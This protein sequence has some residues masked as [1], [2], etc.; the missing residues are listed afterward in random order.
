MG[1]VFYRAFGEKKMTQYF[2]RIRFMR[3]SSFGSFISLAVSSFPAFSLCC[4]LNALLPNDLIFFRRLI[5]LSLFLALP[6]RSW[7][8]PFQFFCPIF[9]LSTKP[10]QDVDVRRELDLSFQPAISV[11]AGSRKRPIEYCSPQKTLW[12]SI[13]R[14]MLQTMPLTESQPQAAWPSVI[15]FKKAAAAV[16]I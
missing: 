4:M 15:C 10:V 1:S 16:W 6:K 9:S 5:P 12:L 14:V 11:P 7:L 13:G 2:K 8:K 3:L